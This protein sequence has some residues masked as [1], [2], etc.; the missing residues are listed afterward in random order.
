MTIL[1]IKRGDF[2]K[3]IGMNPLRVDKANERDLFPF[4]K[5]PGKKTY[6]LEEAVSAHLMFK[7]IGEESEPGHPSS[8][9]SP[10][11]AKW[12][13]QTAMANDKRT[14]SKN[15]EYFPLGSEG[16]LDGK[17]RWIGISAKE[18]AMPGA[19][20]L[21]VLPIYGTM[22]EL[23]AWIDERSPSRVF[24]VNATRG[25]RFV[26]GRLQEIGLMAND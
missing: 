4:S 24:M 11:H 16:N 5:G 14:R 1:Q 15:G 2:A 7:L 17:D 22:T 23:A 6:S 18:K 26:M 21:T 13:M 25:L 10:S 8:G 19:V 20:L 12:I 3:V 9:L